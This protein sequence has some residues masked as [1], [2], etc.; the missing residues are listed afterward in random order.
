MINFLVTVDEEINDSNQPKKATQIL[1]IMMTSPEQTHATRWEEYQSIL[2][3]IRHVDHFEF[4]YPLQF[5]FVTGFMANHKFQFLRRDEYLKGKCVR[6]VTKTVGIGRCVVWR[7]A[8]MGDLQPRDGNR[9]ET[10]SQI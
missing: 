2:P 3:R 10:C 8:G 9:R 4:K 7:K 6:G 1:H 5:Q